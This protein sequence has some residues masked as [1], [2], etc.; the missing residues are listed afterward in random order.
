MQTK[1]IQFGFV[2]KSEIA[3]RLQYQQ[4]INQRLQAGNAGKIDPEALK[5]QPYFQ[6]QEGKIKPIYINR[7]AGEK[8]ISF[9][10]P[11]LKDRANSLH[12]DVRDKPG[13]F[14]EEGKLFL[15]QLNLDELYANPA[16]AAIA[17]LQAVM[18]P[19]ELVAGLQ[20]AIESLKP[21]PQAEP[22]PGKAFKALG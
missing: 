13:N 17:W 19:D 21:V 8:D 9:A 22:T 1:T 7:I 5:S 14:R 4:E 20:K 2:S 15:T 6:V 11:D 18:R 12:A 10:S 3:A 16:E